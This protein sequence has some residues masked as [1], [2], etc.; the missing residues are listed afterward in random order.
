MRA[1]VSRRPTS[2]SE[3]KAEHWNTDVTVARLRRNALAQGALKGLLNVAVVP[4][5][6]AENCVEADFNYYF[7]VRYLSETCLGCL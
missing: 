6:I 2:G 5:D 7:G 1:I 3:R 4:A